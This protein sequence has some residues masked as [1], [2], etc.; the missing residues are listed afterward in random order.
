MKFYRLLL[1]LFP[2]SFRSEYGAEMCEAFAARLERENAFSLWITT[3]FQ[4]ITGAARVHGE[5]LWQDLSWSVRTLRRSPAF[6]IT[7]IV[8][9]AVGIGGNTAAFTLLD[10]VL[11]EPLPYAQPEKLVMVFQSQLA[12]GYARIQ[13]SAANFHDWQTMNKSFE[14][15]GALTPAMINLSGQ[16]APQQLEGVGITFEV[17]KVLGVQPAIGRGFNAADEREGAPDV[18]LLSNSLATSLFGNAAS[19]MGRTIQLDNGPFTVIGVMPAS[20]TFPSRATQVWVPLQFPPSFFTTPESRANLSVNVVARLR[21]G[22]TLAQARSDL[23]QVAVQLEHSYPI[24][25]AGMGTDVAGMREV[26]SPQS[27]MLV[28]AVFGAACCVLLIACT[29]LANLLF[30]RSMVRR[31]EIAVRMAIGAGRERLLRQLFTENF[32]LALIGGVVG[33]LLAMFATPLLARL[34]PNTLAVGGGAEMNLH[35]FWFVTMLTV[36]TCIAFGAGPALQASRHIDATALRMKS[37]SGGRSERLRTMLVLVEITCTV[38]LLVGAGLLLKALWRVQIVNPGFNSDH[39]LTLRTRLP[40]PKYN[41]TQVR[42]QFYSSVLTKTKELPGVSSAAYISFLPMVFGGGIF[43][44]TV[45]GVTANGA[46]SVPTSIR[47]VTPDF[48]TT[49]RI[50]LQRGRD[51][52]GHDIANAPYV[53]VISESLAQ[54]FWPGQDPVG[55]QLNVA[56]FDRTVVGVVSDISVRGPERASEPQV[57]LSSDQV[58]SGTMLFFTPKDLVIRASGD[59]NLLVPSLRRIVRE[60][61]P[62]QA[63]A[64]VQLLEDVVQS[65]TASRRAQLRV[66]CAF[67]VLAFLLAAIG[68]YGLLSFTVSTRTQELGVRLALGA[69]PADILGM[70][71]RKGLILGVAGVAIALPLAYMAA[72]GMAALLFRVQPSDPLVY[73]GAA[74]LAMFLTLVGSVGPAMRAAKTDPAITIRS[75]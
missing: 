15:M 1:R 22:V 47:Y 3:V 59:P 32:V 67:A 39:V 13:T 6:T 4:V 19:S 23:A 57:Y 58:A 66:L 29:N 48:F 62:E 56:F 68:I 51:I 49:L 27:R 74:L 69:K 55:R 64:D 73:I 28:L 9:A 65:Q 20:F 54:R 38:T 10:H 2:L 24:Q 21:P 30:A 26:V 63:I 16:G 33:L 18:V 11:L 25:D 60:A 53:A 42:A 34:V 17:L 41:D 43:P 37:T 75:E 44:V 52:N 61:D 45:P 46:S 72:R 36:V 12:N 35:I 71:L 31:R 40:L 5:I 7:A 70:F 8:V 14:S 50:P